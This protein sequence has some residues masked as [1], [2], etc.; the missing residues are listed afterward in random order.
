M[1]LCDSESS[2]TTR[3]RVVYDSSAKTSSGVS[4]NDIQHVGPVVQDDLFSILMR[5]RQHKYVVTADVEKMYRQILVK[6]E[7]RYLQMILWREQ[8]DQPIKIYQL[9]TITYGTSSAPFLSTRCLVQLAIECSDVRVADVIKDD[10]Y[11]DDVI[12]GSNSKED[13]CFM[14]NSITEVLHSAHLPL[15]KFRSNVGSVL[16]DNSNALIPK[17]LDFT[18]Q[19]SALGLKWDP[20]TDTFNFPVDIKHSSVATKRSILSNSARLFDPLGLLSLCT[21]VPKIIL[22]KLWL[23]KLD[24]DDPIPTDLSKSWFNFVQGLK[25]LT[26]FQIPRFALADDPDAIVELHTFCDASQ[27]AYA[28]CVYLR[29]IS[30]SGDV[31]VNLLCAKT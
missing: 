19:S 10:F 15:R 2:E 7:Q 21:I 1:A 6:P 25:S 14:I 24:W 26:N 30:S 12:T 5:F 27:D 17:D 9:N 22:K 13:L 28:A 18:S 8:S 29:S 11:V 31:S 16:R 3:L 4:F 23:T 20:S